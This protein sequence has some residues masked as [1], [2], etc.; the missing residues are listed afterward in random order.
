MISSFH[1]GQTVDQAGCFPRALRRWYIKPRRP[2]PPADWAVL[3]LTFSFDFIR[4]RLM[5]RFEF[6]ALGHRAKEHFAIVVSLHYKLTKMGLPP[7]GT[8]LSFTQSL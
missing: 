8:H 1:L 7:A 5:F 2:P 6:E 4:V 3:S